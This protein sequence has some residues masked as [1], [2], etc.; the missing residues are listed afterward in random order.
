M[1]RTAHRRPRTHAQVRGQIAQQALGLAVRTRGS[2]HCEH[3][4][5]PN[6]IAAKFLANSAVNCSK[7]SA[8]STYGH[9][10]IHWQRECADLEATLQAQ[11][12]TQATR[13]EQDASCVG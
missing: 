5:A 4:T 12:E 3:V 8:R 2:W 11:Q 7:C 9:F 13:V 6:R 10:P 1:R